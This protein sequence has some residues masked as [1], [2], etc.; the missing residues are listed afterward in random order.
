MNNN[1]INFVYFNEV[2]VAPTSNNNDK[3]MKLKVIY[4]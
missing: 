3:Q 2:E 1:K 4:Q